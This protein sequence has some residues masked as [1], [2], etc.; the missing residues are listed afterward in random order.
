M[1]IWNTG[2]AL[3][4]TILNICQ[5]SQMQTRK[6]NP[7]PHHL[8]L[9]VRHELLQGQS[10]QTKPKNSQA[11][12]RPNSF[13]QFQH[14]LATNVTFYKLVRS[15]FVQEMSQTDIYFLPQPRAR[16]LHVSIMCNGLYIYTTLGNCNKICTTSACGARPAHIHW[17]AWGKESIFH[18]KHLDA[19]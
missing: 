11:M 7:L 13:T 8:G 19:T 3:H 16:I 4:G 1:S 17:Q 5:L 2:K 6:P 9:Q 18:G 15:I 10:D 12:W 14:V